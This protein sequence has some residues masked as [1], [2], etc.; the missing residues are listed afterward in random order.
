MQVQQGG[1]GQEQGL[2]CHTSRNEELSSNRSDQQVSRGITRGYD[3]Y[4]FCVAQMCSAP[5]ILFYLHQHREFCVTETQNTYL[6][7][8]S[9]FAI[10]FLLETRCRR[11]RTPPVSIGGW[12]G[13][14]LCAALLKWLFRVLSSGTKAGMRYLPYDTRVRFIQVR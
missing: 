8:V 13:K 12:L 11:K 10:I 9:S 3:F 14:Q 1:A 4:R 7:C 5:K 2:S 6:V